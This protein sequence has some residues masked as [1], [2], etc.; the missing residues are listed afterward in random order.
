MATRT[1]RSKSRYPAKRGNKRKY[2][3]NVGMFRRI[4]CHIQSKIYANK[5]ED[6]KEDESK[7]SFKRKNTT[8][9]FGISEEVER[10]YNIYT[11]D[12]KSK[13]KESRKK[14]SFYNSDGSFNCIGILLGMCSD[15]DYIREKSRKLCFV[16]LDGIIKSEDFM[17]LTAM[18]FTTSVCF[19]FY[20]TFFFNV[21][22]FLKH[23]FNIII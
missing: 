1:T 17:D 7:T 3:P 4:V 23:N 15:D 13:N 21:T 6:N 18:I 9:V 20:F 14:V 12:R 16:N 8:G 19:Y 10:D 22:E 5:V 2:N 11:I